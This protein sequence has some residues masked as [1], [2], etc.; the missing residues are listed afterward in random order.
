MF[1]AIALAVIGF[2]AT[3]SAGV[4]EI[5]KENWLQA[6]PK[7]S[8]IKMQLQGSSH[9]RLASTATPVKWSECQS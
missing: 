5:P 4:L 7:S 1:K 2:L 3:A 6:T 9:M 8:P